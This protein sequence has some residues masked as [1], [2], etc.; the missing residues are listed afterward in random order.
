[1]EYIR[2]IVD[3]VIDKRTEAFNAVILTA[4]NASVLL[5]ITSS[6]ILLIYSIIIPPRTIKYILLHIHDL[7]Q[8]YFVFFGKFILFF[9][10][11]LFCVFRQIYFTFFSFLLY[12]PYT[13]HS[14]SSSSILRSWLYLATRSV[15]AGAPVLICPAFMPTAM[16]AIV[17]SSVSP[18]R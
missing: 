5:S 6:T 11:I 16:S 14:P 15:R 7:L 2:R 12:P 4:L 8:A 17:V 18:E 3:D 9:S 10:A 1:M 13:V